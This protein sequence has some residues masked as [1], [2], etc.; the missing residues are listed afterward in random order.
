MADDKD[1]HMGVA[2]ESEISPPF[3][4]IDPEDLLEVDIELDDDTV[5]QEEDGED[6]KDDIEAA[7]PNARLMAEDEADEAEP[8]PNDDP[9][10]DFARNQRV[11]QRLLQERVDSEMRA[12]A[13]QMQSDVAR[14]EAE[15]GRADAVL[16]NVKARIA[17]AR[18]DI[19]RAIDDEDTHTASDLNA[20]MGELQKTQSE[21]EA[22]RGQLPSKEQIEEAYHRQ[23]ETRQ[24]EIMRES[25]PQMPQAANE[26]A[27]QWQ[28]KNSW[29]AD[30]KWQHVNQ[31][32]IKFNN[33]LLAGGWNADYPSFYQKLG[34]MLQAKYPDLPLRDKA[35]R[36][37]GQPTQQRRP[38]PRQG[39]RP[40]VASAQRTETSRGSE[41]RKTKAG[42]T[43]VRLDAAD[44]A[45]IRALGRD[46]SDKAFLREFAENKAERLREEA[47]IK[48]ARG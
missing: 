1:M 41:M 7:D 44:K 31:D 47:A 13:G 48:R 15:V 2:D 42:K 35:G 19:Q 45:V 28:A 32:L 8:E 43:I 26:E 23:A 17:E 21:V 33:E 36:A 40:P 10:S 22:Y 46:P 38:A 18:R 25:G 11:Q 9:N 24:H 39:Q 34:K 4:N 6:V 30:P 5:I 29:M 27:R 14:Y 3:H 12:M 37:F 16:D 20:L